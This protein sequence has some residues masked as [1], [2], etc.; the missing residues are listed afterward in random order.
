VFADMLDLAQELR[1]RGAELLIC[2][3]A[4]EALALATTPLPLAGGLPEWLSPVTAIVPGQ[5]LAL[6]LALARGLAPDTPRGLQKVTLT[7]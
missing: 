1:G 6:H 5:T 4:P 3:D 2:S 7:V